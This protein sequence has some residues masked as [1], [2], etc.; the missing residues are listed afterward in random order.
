[1]MGYTVRSKINLVVEVT[2]T[3]PWPEDVTVKQVREQSSREA[4]EKLEAIFRG[5]GSILHPS[6]VKV[7]GVPDVTV[8]SV[9]EA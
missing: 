4:L 5:N 8:V 2:T 9:R 6:G 3:Q 7:V 1:M